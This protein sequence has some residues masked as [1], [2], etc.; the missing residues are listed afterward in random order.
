MIYAYDQGVQLPISSIYDTQMRLAYISTAKDMYEKAV[1]EMKDFKK[2]YGDFMSPFWKDMDRYSQM[3]GGIQNLIQN[4]YDNGV[5]L[6]KSLE[7]RRI[8]RKAINSIDIGE[9][10]AMKANAKVGYAYLDAQRKL[11]SQ[12][13]Y[14]E[15]QELFAMGGKRFSDFQTRNSDGTFNIWDRPSPI[16]AVSLRDLTYKNYEHR[17]PR[18]L[19]VDDFKNDPSLRGIQFNPRYQYTGYLYSDLMKVA[20]GVSTSLAGDPRAA[21]FRD[22]ARQKVVASGMPVTEE[23][24]EAQFQ[25][26]IADVNRWALVNPTKKADDFAKMDYTFRQQVALENI[27]AKNDKE[28]AQI[29]TGAKDGVDDRYSAS[30][31]MAV[32]SEG[33]LRGQLTN[34]MDP[35]IAKKLNKYENDVVS[36]LKDIIKNSSKYTEDEKTEY[37]QKYKGMAKYRERAALDGVAKTVLGI[38]KSTKYF[39]DT[40]EKLNNILR[41]LSANSI[42]IQT[43]TSILRNIG[44]SDSGDG[45]TYVRRD[46]LCGIGNV[47]N[48]VLSRG[49]YNGKTT[50]AIK[51]AKNRLTEGDLKS[52]G[53]SWT[54]GAFDIRNEVDDVMWFNSNKSPMYPTGNVVSGNDNYY[55]EVSNSPSDFDECCWVKVERDKVNGGGISPTLSSAMQ[56]VDA[57]FLHNFSNSNVPGNIQSAVGE[58]NK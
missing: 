20:A 45:G 19:T 34:Y 17:T 26:D 25:R 52:Y 9:Y 18:D 28:I 39:T 2:E 30:L 56:A 21:F 31:N 1:Q 15:A 58:Y 54:S 53:V 24:V 8:I 6:A 32:D 41:D 33:A 50:Q 40:P 49:M 10:N 38:G 47:M 57:G 36:K 22:Q 13:K 4:A 51:D 14:S 29:R 16:E 27:R 3:V 37:I 12:E 35:D 42:P 7:G 43:L 23:A 5:D 55:I 11:I 48:D 44:G 46:R